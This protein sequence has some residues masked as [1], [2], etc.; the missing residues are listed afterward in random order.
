MKVLPIFSFRRTHSGT[1]NAVSAILAGT[2]FRWAI[3]ENDWRIRLID[4][5]ARRDPSTNCTTVLSRPR[6]GRQSSSTS[7]GRFASGIRGATS[8]G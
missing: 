8:K 6:S 3:A 1:R 2:N 4:R 5:Q 7:A